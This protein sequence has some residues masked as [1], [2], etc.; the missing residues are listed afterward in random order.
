MKLVSNHPIKINEQIGTH[1]TTNE[2]NQTFQALDTHLP[3]KNHHSDP[4][5]FK[6]GVPT[7]FLL[8]VNVHLGMPEIS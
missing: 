5:S 8:V 4:Q 6:P 3:K 2:K 7:C 1:L